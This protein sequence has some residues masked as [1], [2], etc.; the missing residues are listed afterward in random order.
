MAVWL[1]DTEVVRDLAEKA[2]TPVVEPAPVGGNHNMP[3]K[4]TSTPDYGCIWIAGPPNTGKTTSLR[5][6]T[7]PMG[8]I[9]VPGEKGTPASHTVKV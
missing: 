4:Q 6:A 9:S 2:V 7:K 1:K 8:I 3:L 5:T